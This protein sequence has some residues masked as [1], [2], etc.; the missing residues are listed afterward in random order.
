MPKVDIC[1]NFYLFIYFADENALVEMFPW[2]PKIMQEK[3]L[4]G[5]SG[6][7]EASFSIKNSCTDLTENVRLK[8]WGV[9][10]RSQCAFEQSATALTA[11][12]MCSRRRWLIR[13]RVHVQNRRWLSRLEQSGCLTQAVSLLIF[14]LFF[15]SIS[16][17]I[18]FSRVQFSLLCF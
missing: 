17:F 16:Q 2:R 4:L 9:P 18:P 8:P 3:Y 15:S 12:F 11:C 13:K 10:N 7:L 14:L 1:I 6:L 5:A